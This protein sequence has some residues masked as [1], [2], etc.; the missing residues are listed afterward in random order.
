MS[1]CRM[2]FIFSSTPTPRATMVCEVS[3]SMPGAAALQEQ[4]HGNET[5][6]VKVPSKSQHPF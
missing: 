5:R 1:L 6:V 3:D 4:K 2:Q